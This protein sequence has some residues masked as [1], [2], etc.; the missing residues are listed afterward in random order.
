MTLTEAQRRAQ[1]KWQ[2]KATVMIS[3]R[4]QRGSDADIIAYLDGEARQTII[5]LALREY[6]NNHPKE[7]TSSPDKPFWEE[8]EEEEN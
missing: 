1:Y 6:M 5:K 4:L 3:V 7:T 2:K 8:L